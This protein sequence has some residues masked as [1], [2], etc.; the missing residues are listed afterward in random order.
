MSEH[1]SF[2]AWRFYF[3]LSLI[4]TGVLGLTFRIFDLSILDQRFLRQ[5]GDERVLRLI[6]IPAYRGMILD[7]NDIPLAISTSVY[8]IWANPQEF[9]ISK[10]SLFSLSKL[11]DLK[12][13]QILQM[14]HPS[15]SG[16]KQFVYLKRSLSP[17]ITERIKAL[18]I[19][20]VYWQEQYRRYYPD[21]EITAH[22]IGFTDVDDN[23]QEGL[24]LS[25][26]PWLRG[27]PGKRWVMKD[28]LGR[29]I[30]DLQ[31][32]QQQKPGHDL[33]LS[34]DRRIQY[35]AYREL[36]AGVKQNQAGSGSA[37]VLDAK[38]GEVLAM[39]N[40]PSF[41][42]NQNKERKGENIRN[43]AITDVFEPGST[44]KA[45]SVACALDSGRYQT[46]T[47]I[48]TY[49]GWMRVD[50]KL[51]PDE[52]N[53]GEISVGK[54]LQVSSNVGVSKMILNLPAD[55]L[56]NLLHRVGFGEITGIGFP[57]EQSG[58][59]VQRYPW[60]AFT[61]CTLA[62]GYG[63]SVTALQLARAYSVLAHDGVK[64]PISLLR[65]DHPPPG[66]QV[67]QPRLASEMLNLL[68]SVVTQG[69]G[70]HAM[71]PNYRVAG[72][73]GTTR[74]VGKKGYE[75][76][77]HTSSFVGIAPVE[78]PR[79]VVAVV[80]HNLQGKN[81]HGGDVSGPVFEKIMEES[82]RMLDIPPDKA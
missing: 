67:I 18:Q 75:K 35:I 63:M 44:I 1:T 14:V 52:K 81:Y 77:H 74:M 69:T 36:L 66:E 60:G 12:P 24:E 27:E 30:A 4:L 72:K 29:I 76:H 56:W 59:L 2:I 64:M 62:F 78:N 48:N 22:I 19:P 51:I 55:S 50:H 43:R 3:V 23:G 28:R 58:A 8:S 79:L 49:P 68:E 25:Y 17:A 73:T 53:Y 33:V 57:G 71:I 20:G 38:T 21:G 6:Q 39:V 10:S 7:R 46:D 61:L 32:V 41:N 16:K 5:Q 31:T 47:M 13:N 42:P 45:F 40:Q 15:H 34:I 26:N 65:L 11:L 37:I 54:V 82:L 70:K 80:I 9:N